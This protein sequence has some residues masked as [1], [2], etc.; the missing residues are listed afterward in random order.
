MDWSRVDFI[1]LQQ[2]QEIILTM[3][4][5]LPAGYSQVTLSFTDSYLPFQRYVFSFILAMATESELQEIQIK[6]KWISVK[7]F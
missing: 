7:F 1:I 2:N 3:L 5:E 6:N 4:E